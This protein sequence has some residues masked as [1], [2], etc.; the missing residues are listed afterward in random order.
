MPAPTSLRHLLALPLRAAAAALLLCVVFAPRSLLAHDPLEITASAFLAKRGLDIDLEMPIEVAVSAVAPEPILIE[1]VTLADFPHWKERIAAAAPAFLAI[2]S[3][4]GNIAAEVLAVELTREDDVRI[5]YRYSG[6]DIES[7]T[8]RAPMIERLPDYGYGVYLR[9]RD[10]Q[11][12]WREPAAI[13][14]RSPE[15]R[16]R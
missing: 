8:I 1:G 6:A 3:G 5:R 16:P 13:M 11:G 10:A 15:Y 4:E 9:F 14:A 2:G 7:L 12:L